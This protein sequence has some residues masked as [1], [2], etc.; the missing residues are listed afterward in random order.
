MNRK[1]TI[2]EREFQASGYPVLTVLVHPDPATYLH[3]V[4][5]TPNTDDATA[6]VI[7]DDIL[8]KYSGVWRRLSEL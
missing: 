3:G 6:D 8:R 2:E 4:V 5:C 7:V 1:I